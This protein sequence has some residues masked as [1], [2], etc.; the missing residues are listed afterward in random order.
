M[1]FSVGVE[2]L[3]LRARAAAAQRRSRTA[4][5]PV[6]LRKAVHD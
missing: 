1:A 6:K 5:R 3:N 4:A 2:L